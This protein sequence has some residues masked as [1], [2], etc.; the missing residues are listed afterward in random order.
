[1]ERET[2]FEPAT[3]SLGKQ[4]YIDSQ[5]FSELQRPPSAMKFP[6]FPGFESE[7]NH[8]GITS[9]TRTASPKSYGNLSLQPGN[10]K[11]VC[12]L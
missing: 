9:S 6:Q 5:G 7:W 10:V 2:G 12:G 8:N 3:S 4:H 1:M 11:V